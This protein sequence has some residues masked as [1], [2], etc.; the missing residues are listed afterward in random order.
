MG[1]APEA[2]PF[3]SRAAEGLPRRSRVHYN[4]GLLLQ[5]LGRA[6]EA[7]GALAR[8]AG[9]EPENLDFLLA[10]AD[11]YLKRGLLLRAGAV[12]DRMIAAHPEVSAGHEVKA[13]VERSLEA[14]GEGR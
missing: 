5:S 3:L 14:G 11:H 9:L 4:H 12:A 10:L 2:L 7:E 6:E 1:R 13:L 8:A